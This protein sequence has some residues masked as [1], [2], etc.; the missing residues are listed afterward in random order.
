MLTSN[1]TGIRWYDNEPDRIGYETGCS[2]SHRVYHFLVADPGMSLY[3]DKAIKELEPELVKK[4]ADWN[5]KLKTPYTK[6]DIKRLRELSYVVDDLWKKQKEQQRAMRMQTQDALSI[7]GHEE[8]SRFA[9]TS[10]RQKDRIYSQYYLSEHERNAG[11]FARLKFAMDYWCALWFWPIEEADELPTRDEFIMV[12][13]IILGGTVGKAIDSYRTAEPQTRILWEEDD[14]NEPE[15]L[16]IANLQ[17]AYGLENEVDLDKLCERFRRF[18]LVREITGKQHFFHWE[19]EFADVFE[20]K[21]GFDLIIGNPPWVKLEWN[22]QAVLSDEDPRF[23]IKGL[24]AAQTRASPWRTNALA[25]DSIRRSY[26]DE[27]VTMTATKTFLNATQ[28]YPLLKGQQTNLYRCFLPQ[29]WE[30]S[31]EQ[32][33]S[34]F[35]HPDGILG[36]ANANKMRFEML[37][38]YRKHF[39]FE[40]EHNLFKGTNDHGRMRFSLN[41]YASEQH[42]P[43]FLSIN[44]LFEPET[45]EECLVSKSIGIVPGIK[46]D[47]GNWETRGH[48]S[49][50]IRVGRKELTAFSRLLADDEW[51]S[52][53]VLNIH[54][55][56]LMDVLEVIAMRNMT[57]RSDSMFVF[58][59]QCWHE[60]GA[61]RAG[62]IVDEIAF[63]ESSKEVVLSGAHIGTSNPLFQVTRA[64]Y[65]SPNDYDAVDLETIG[66]T[67]YVRTKYRRGVSRAE[68][69]A[70]IPKVD[71]GSSFDSLYRVVFRDMV[72]CSSE[73]TLQAAIAPPGQMWINKLLGAYVSTSEP[74]INK[75]RTSRYRLLAWVAGCMA[76]LPLDYAIRA[77]GKGDL[78]VDNIYMI[79]VVE[80]PFFDE[81]VCRALLLNCLTRDY[82][83]LWADCWDDEFVD[84]SWSKTDSRLPKSTFSDLTDAWEWGTPLR[85]DYERRQALVELDVL[86]SLAL[87]LTLEQLETVYRLDFSV[88]Q[89][90]ENDTWYDRNGR[91][92]F[93]KKNL[94][95]SKPSRQEFEAKR[96]AGQNIEVTY[97]DDTLPGGP[98]ERTVRYEAPY[99]MCDRIE[100]YRTAWKFFAEK[101]NL[102]GGA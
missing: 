11:P 94:G 81:V 4:I 73:R 76:S 99:D 58:S 14:L 54:A 37:R 15:Q 13:D 96:D 42:E 43:D 39:Q 65:R 48:S 36:D 18:A 40:N 82:A 87:G 92:A 28:N 57:L 17:E 68:Y 56:P 49:R 12:M 7:F 52:A 24:T 38:R 95:A 45:I 66:E 33:V 27:Y 77:I 74:W 80:T 1:A 32:G 69:D 98:R 70:L 23:A 10:I 93:S 84:F 102:E 35:V 16:Q 46:N 75:N 64:T 100:D 41:V 3:K 63:P 5:K 8:S 6:E 47:G 90:Y 60:T 85:R 101:Y 86:V 79:P 26:L 61:R 34:A 71:N 51:H 50:A 67:Y 29:A 44:N 97:T 59:S 55:Q 31:S 89:S 53:R 78:T 9:K 25:A 91:I 88:L 72:G 30:H 2:K 83:A 20:E 22:E 62:T 19:L 21:G